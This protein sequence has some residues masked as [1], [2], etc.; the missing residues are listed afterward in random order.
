[1]REPRSAYDQWPPCREVTS[2]VGRLYGKMHVQ[3]WDMIVFGLMQPA[4]THKGYESQGCSLREIT[5]VLQ[6]QLPATHC[7][8]S[9]PQRLQ[10][11]TPRAVTSEFVPVG[12]LDTV[13]F[14]ITAL[15]GC[16][17]SALTSLDCPTKEAMQYFGSS[18]WWCARL[19]LT[20]GSYVATI[21]SYKPA[22]KSTPVPADLRTHKLDGETC[23]REMPRPDIQKIWEKIYEVMWW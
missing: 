19:S 17:L 7:W 12:S 22:A 2:A 13:L 6:A 1:M 15:D 4:V 14:Y 11:M 3:R 18:S 5:L 23:T 9:V 16:T 21:G 8:V 10:V 20:G